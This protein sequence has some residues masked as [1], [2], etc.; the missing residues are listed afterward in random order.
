MFLAFLCHELRNPLQVITANTD[1]L[2]EDAAESVAQGAATQHSA[3]LSADQRE[4]ITSIN[5]SAEMMLS[6]VNDVLDMSRLQSGRMSFERLPIDLHFIC[7]SILNISRSQASSKNL[8]LELHIE[9]AV[10][11]FVIS[12]PTRIHQL[13]LNLISNGLCTPAP[14][15]SVASHAS[16]DELWFLIFPFCCW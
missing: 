16:I 13:L 6:I 11:R 4:L 5:A 9:E 1:F 8:R 15:R 2:L 10:P 14:G 7:H 12:D 3:T